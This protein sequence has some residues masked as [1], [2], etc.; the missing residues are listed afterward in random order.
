MPL[1]S[2]EAECVCF[3]LCF[4]SSGMEAVCAIGLN[5]ASGQALTGSY[6]ILT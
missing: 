2:T 3:V 5:N 4:A 1:V 6:T